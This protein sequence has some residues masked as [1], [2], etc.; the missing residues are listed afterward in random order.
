MR[1]PKSLALVLAAAAVAACATID[2]TPDAPSVSQS[3]RQ[4]A[5]QQHEQILAEF[6]GAVQGPQAAYVA[7][8]GERMASAAGVPGGCTFSLVNTDVVNA[9]AVPG[10]YIYVTRGLLS[11]ANS[12]AELAYVLGHEVGHV[13]ADHS[14]RRQNAGLLS[15]LGAIAVGVLTGSGDLARLV[16]QGA[17]LF[18]L[19]YSREQEYESDDLGVRY[20]VR[21]GYDPFAAPDMLEQL[22]AQD[23]LEARTRNREAQA[24]PEWSR[25]H[26]LTG[27]RV[28]RAVQQ[29]QATGVPPGSRP[30]EEAAYY[31]AVDGMIY[32]DDPEQGFVDGRTFAHP[33]L[34]IAFEAPPGFTLQNTSRAVLVQGPNGARAQFSGGRSQGSLDDHAIGVLRQLL[35]RTQAQVGTPRRTTINGLDAV[36]YPARAQTQSGVVDV[37]V[38]AYRFGPDTAYHF[39]SVAPAGRSGVFEPL[40]G[41]VRRLTDA[42]A[43]Q[44]RPRRIEVVT[45]RAGDTV[46]SLANRMAFSDLRLERFLVLNDLD[47]NTALRPGRRVKIVVYGR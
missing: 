32:G 7:R 5:A 39:V 38:V 15:G 2:S 9:F 13:V 27:N 22:Q 3:E 23:A 16:G 46:Q 14:A 43:A 42:Q 10:C 8:V 40:F 29:A 11:I 18:T 17:Q 45:L 24:V 25:T 33:T 35:G 1:R 6:G 26:P 34:R 31:A 41:S 21:A 28:A 37:T 36:I 12:E 20:L 47:P 30:R 44:L 4:R 19:R